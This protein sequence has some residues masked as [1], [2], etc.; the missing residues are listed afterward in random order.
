MIH[1]CY[2]TILSATFAPTYLEYIT[3][4][5]NSFD[6]DT[7]SLDIYCTKTHDLKTSV[8]RGNAAN[9]LLRLCERLLATNSNFPIEGEEEEEI[10][11]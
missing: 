8:G 1:S 5:S 2:I 11:E 9:D 7:P 6:G 3:G 10:D 4:K